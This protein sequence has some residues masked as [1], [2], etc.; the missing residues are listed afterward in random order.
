[1]RIYM[2]NIPGKFYPDPISN[3]GALRFLRG[4][5]IKKKNNNNNSNNKMSS[6]MR[7]VPD[8]DINNDALHG[9]SGSLTSF[10]RWSRAAG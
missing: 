1:M 6:D 5:H 8:V 9:P 4:R 3:E 7:S 10:S 2:K